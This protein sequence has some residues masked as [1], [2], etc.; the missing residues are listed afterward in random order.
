M[1]LSTVSD[2]STQKR[3]LTNFKITNLTE[4]FEIHV[5]NA[6]VSNLLST[7]NEIPP[8]NRDLQQFD[9]LKDFEVN[10]LEEQS[11]NVLL[12]A[13]HAHSFCINKPIVGKPNDPIGMITKF[14]LALIGPKFQPSVNSMPMEINYTNYDNIMSFTV[15][16]MNVVDMIN[17][18]F[19]MDFIARHGELFPA[20]HVF[21]SVN[22]DI[23]LKQLEE[24]LTYDPTEKR[25]TVGL[26]WRLGREK[27]AEIFSKINFLKMAE[28]RHIKFGEKL[29][30]DP[31][32]KSGSFKQ[33]NMTIADDHIRVLD[34]LD[35]PPGSPVCYLPNLV[36]VKPNKPG[37][38]RICQ[39]AAAKVGKHSL[40][41]FLFSGPDLLNKLIS[42][43]LRFRQKKYTLSADISNFF[44]QIKIDPRDASAL[45]YLWWSDETLREIIMHESTR[46]IFGIKSSPT[47]A[48]YVLKKHAEKF[49]NKMSYETFIAILLCFYVD[50]LLTSTDT[51]EEA[52]KLKTELIDILLLG[53]FSLTKW[54]SNIPEL[55]DNPVTSTNGNSN[56]SNISSTSQ[57]PQ[58]SVVHDRPGDGEKTHD[59]SVEKEATPSSEENNCPGSGFPRG[60]IL[61]HQSILCPGSVFGRRFPGGSVLH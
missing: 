28:N 43:I 37:K 7:E 11:I 20:E 44:Y 5:E 1:K 53:G 26:P 51:I 41:N 18:M 13:K 29:E 22:D 39:D 58:G 46:H 23:A 36:V 50:D 45:R 8:R 6:L 4:T 59:E 40:N 61:A 34:N 48:N 2:R 10:E 35:A 56:I 49:K 12:D 54:K 3:P 14:G 38:F 19:R 31:V 55:C 30:K 42:V 32:L 52:T 9:H 27:T 47:I 17:R 24:T 57:V 16:D 21:P 33:M 60:S 15:D 25:W